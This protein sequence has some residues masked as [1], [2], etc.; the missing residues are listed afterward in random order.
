MDNRQE[1]LLVNNQPANQLVQKHNRNAV[2]SI[3]L[4][5]SSQPWGSKSIH[6]IEKGSINGK[7][8][9]LTMRFKLSDISGSNLYLPP[10]SYFVDY[11]E[12]KQDGQIIHQLYDDEL[13]DV[14]LGFHT[15]KERM[16]SKLKNMGLNNNF[17][18]STVLASNQTT[19]RY[20]DVPINFL[21]LRPLISA[22]TLASDIYIEIQW[23]SSIASTNPNLNNLDLLFEMETLHKNEKNKQLNLVK[24]LVP[25]IYLRTVKIEGSNNWAASTKYDNYITL[26][27]VQGL[28]PFMVLKLRSSLSNTNQGYLKNVDLGNS[29]VDLQDASGTSRY[30]PTAVDLNYIRNWSNVE[31]LPND[32]FNNRGAY[33]ISAS[34]HVLEAYKGSVANYWIMD[35][36][37][38]RLSIQTASAPVNHVQRVASNAD[39][40]AGTF[41][42]K[43]RGSSVSFAYNVTCAT[44]SSALNSLQSALNHPNG[45]I[46]FVVGPNDA[47]ACFNTGGATNRDITITSQTVNGFDPQ[48]DLIEVT[49][50]QTTRFNTSVH[51]Y[52]QTGFV[53]GSYVHT[54]MVYVFSCVKMNNGRVFKD[55]NILDYIRM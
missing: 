32:Y 54:L 39:L 51:Q 1:I 20:L 50:D 27:S 26:E 15:V 19:Y 38:S 8:K 36:S 48:E 29:T 9:R 44:V 34:D 42:V 53:S 40:T 46:T 16:S 23:K 47:T 6:K 5:V 55:D 31:H 33:L 11:I 10:S 43:W 18:V 28:V 14:N 22:E 2:V 17:Y 21:K 52:G 3:P 30:A 37:K 45:P 41:T 35:G 25:K 24:E 4:V 7:V 12:I 49:T 13:H